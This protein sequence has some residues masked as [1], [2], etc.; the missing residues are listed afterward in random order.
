MK[1]NEKRGRS[2]GGNNQSFQLKYWALILIF[3]FLQ[4]GTRTVSVFSRPFRKSYRAII[5]L[6]S[7]SQSLFRL[8]LLPLPTWTLLPLTPCPPTPTP[9]LLVCSSLSSI[10]QPNGGGK[11]MPACHFHYTHAYFHLEGFFSSPSRTTI[12]RGKKPMSIKHPTFFSAVLWG[13]THMRPLK[14]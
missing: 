10:W 4:A 7:N 8:S 11:L 1:N 2:K 14:C 12:T 13:L 3:P 5:A 9:T 6:L